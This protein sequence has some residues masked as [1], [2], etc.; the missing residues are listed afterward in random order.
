MQHCCAIKTLS[1]CYK[2]TCAVDLCKMSG[3][4]DTS[5]SLVAVK[6]LKP[7]TAETVQFQQEA[8]ILP[9]LKHRSDSSRC[10][11]VNLLRS[12]ITQDFVSLRRVSP[13]FKER[14]RF[15]PGSKQAVGVLFN[16][17]DSVGCRRYSIFWSCTRI[18]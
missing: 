2:W 5:A 14:T 7:S 15:I 4:S 1:F 11:L 3:S 10:S 8:H 18:S 16:V 6:R 12:K 9:T 17:F 13:M